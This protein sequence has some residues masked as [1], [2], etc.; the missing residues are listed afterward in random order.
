MA[1]TSLFWYGRMSSGSP[2]D[3]GGYDD[4][5]FALLVGLLLGNQSGVYGGLQ[6]AQATPASKSVEVAAG[7]A[8]IKGRMYRS[9]AVESLTIEDN[10]SGNPRIDVIALR[11]DYTAQTIRLAVI[12]GTPAA[13]PVAPALTQVE[14]TTWE[15]YIAQVAVANGF[16]SI[17]D[18]ALTDWRQVRQPGWVAG[19]VKPWGSGTIPDGWLLADGAAV[20]RA[21]YPELFACFGETFG[22]GDGTTTFNLPDLRGRAIFGLDNMGGSSANRLTDSAADILGG[23]P[24]DEAAILEAGNLPPHAHTLENASAAAV[25]SGS[26]LHVIQ[27]EATGSISTS[28]EGDADPFSIVQPGLGLNMI[29]KY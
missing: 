9:T 12:K 19:D 20:S 4:D 10:T 8:V 28:T 1:Q 21:R 26:P 29:V 25:S 11:K 13:A 3:A 18:A 7:T 6:A 27:I 14:G 16:S 23:D 22:A 24:G 17:E 15:E 2:G 5:T